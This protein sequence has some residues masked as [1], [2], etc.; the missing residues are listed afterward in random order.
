MYIRKMKSRSRLVQNINS[1]A[2]ASSCQLRCQLDSLGFP[3]GKGCGRLSQLHIGKPHI[4]KS[5]YLV[6]D[7]GD[8]FKERKRL[9]HCHIQHIKNTLSLIFDIQC[10]PVVPLA[11]ADL[12]GYINV[13]QKVHFYLDDTVTAACLAAS[14]LYIKAEPSL[15]IALCLGIRRRSKQIS[16]LVKDTGIGCRVGTGCP[17]DR[18]LV[19]INHLVKLLNSLDS[20]MFSGNTSCPVQIP[21]KMLIQ[22][23][24]DQRA[25]SGT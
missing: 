19:D 6:P 3:T 16:Y 2:G 11:A 8:I 13:R 1:L 5:L 22:N 9:L 7:R 24:I 12:T 18:G 10:F 23:F 14:A 21:C 20:L 17:P 25:F 15:S 4:I